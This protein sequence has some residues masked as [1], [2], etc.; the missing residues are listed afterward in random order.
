MAM[1]DLDHADFNYL[2]MLTHH[3]MPSQVEWNAHLL[4][5][6]RPEGYLGAALLVAI[7]AHLRMRINELERIEE[8]AASTKLEKALGFIRQALPDYAQW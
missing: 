3:L 1:P 4:F 5:E 8:F 7:Y 2:L 6:D